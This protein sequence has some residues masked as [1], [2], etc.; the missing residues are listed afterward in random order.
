MRELQLHILTDGSNTVPA[1][2]LVNYPKLESHMN[3]MPQSC[4]SAAGYPIRLHGTEARNRKISSLPISSS[5]SLERDTSSYLPLLN[6]SQ[7]I[8]DD[9][10]LSL[11]IGGG[12]EIKSNSKFS[13]RE[14][15]SQL[16]DPLSSQCMNP[17]NA[18]SP[19]NSSS[20]TPFV[21]F[22]TD[23]GGLSSSLLSRDNGVLYGNTSS[24]INEIQFPGFQ[25]SQSNLQSNFLAT[26]DDFGFNLDSSLLPSG[27][28]V[29]PQCGFVNQSP[30]WTR[31]PTPTSFASQVNPLQQQ[32]IR[33]SSINAS[34]ESSLDRGSSMGHAQRERLSPLAEARRPQNT[35]GGCFLGS[36]QPVGIISLQAEGTG[37]G[38]TNSFPSPSSFQPAGQAPSSH[39]VS[40]IAG[41]S[42]I[43][44]ILANPNPI[45]NPIPFPYAAAGTFST[46]IGV[47]PTAPTA[48]TIE[49]RHQRGAPAQVPTVSPRRDY[50]IGEATPSARHGVGSHGVVSHSH[51]KRQATTN[52]LSEHLIQR[53][54]ITPQP[55]LTDK[56][57]TGKRPSSPAIRTPTVIDKLATSKRP[58]SPTRAPITAI[59]RIPPE[60]HFHIR[61]EGC[62]EPLE[63]SG[64]KCFL[65]KRDISFTADGQMY[66]PL[67]PP[68]A[69]VLPCGHTFHDGCLQKI[70]TQGCSKYPPCI[71]CALGEK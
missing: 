39:N 9:D 23:D 41:I 61:W 57:A 27:I 40:S 32:Y 7:Q 52:T 24:R 20:L 67:I 33:R 58:S 36:G 50:S 22:Q 55:A 14:I 46:N 31:I 10:F 19:M 26:Y 70:T 37:D 51:L 5:P 54:R 6:S 44:E 56:L 68:A 11:G 30:L 59:N 65:C 29:V 34:S 64:H 43:A 47:Q 45:V 53:R 1:D 4:E 28:P 38:V 35:V 13:T 63:P 71:P 25:A 60:A 17:I 42:S 62:D 18:Q 66:Q 48:R 8:V 12:M 15:A 3:F 16:K 49:G 69:A 21:G 2:C